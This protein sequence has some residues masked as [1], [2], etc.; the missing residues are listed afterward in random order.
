MS[1]PS[2]IQ[3]IVQTQMQWIPQLALLFGG[4]VLSILGGF[5][6]VIARLRLERKQEIDYIKISLIDELEELVVIIG[7]MLKTQETAKSLPKIYLDD[8]LENTESF[9]EHKKRLFLINK[10]EVRKAI[11]DFYKKLESGIKSS[12]NAVGTLDESNTQQAAEVTKVVNS[13]TLMK[14]EA[15]DLQTTISTYKYKILW[16]I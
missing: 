9:K 15:T 5:F 16:L 4:G 3:C 8:M 1:D 12:N 6:A 13:F 2:Q 7:N 11:C 10:K 14:T